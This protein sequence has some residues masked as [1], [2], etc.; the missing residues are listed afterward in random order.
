MKYTAYDTVNGIAIISGVSE[1][2]AMC[3]VWEDDGFKV[4]GETE[5]ELNDLFQDAL[6]RGGYDKNKYWILTDDD[7][8]NYISASQNEDDD[9]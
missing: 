7:F 4:T 1:V 3:A 6:D 8:A 2:D 9:D 5:K